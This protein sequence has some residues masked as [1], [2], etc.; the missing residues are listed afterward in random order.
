L[1]FVGVIVS[2]EAGGCPTE[3]GTWA[4]VNTQPHR[5]RLA[6]TNLSRQNFDVYCPMILKRV[7]HARRAQDVLRPLFLGYVFVAVDPDLQRWRPIL[8]TFGVRTLIRTGERPSLLSDAFIQGIKAR[9]IDGAIVRPDA[10]YRLGQ[11][12]RLSGGAFDGLVATIIAMDE[13][14]RLVVLMDLLNRPVKVRVDVG[15]VVAA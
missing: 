9:E 15:L 14:D 3:P 12:V 6:V 8:S 5:E 10:P 2:R 11:Q 1:A 4:V 7:R 13:K